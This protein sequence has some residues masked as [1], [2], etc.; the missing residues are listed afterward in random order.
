[1][2]YRDSIGETER[3]FAPREIKFM[4]IMLFTE[5]I[6]KS[7]KDIILYIR[8]D[9]DCQKPNFFFG[10]RGIA[11]TLDNLTRLCNF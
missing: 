6:F 7:N 4:T 5:K 3:L 9:N 1:M 11:Y 8:N 2:N 10:I